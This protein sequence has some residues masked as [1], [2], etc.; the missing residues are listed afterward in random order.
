MP[1]HQSGCGESRHGD[2]VSKLHG[3]P[4]GRERD[5]G[6]AIDGLEDRRLSVTDLVRF[7]ER[8]DHREQH[9]RNP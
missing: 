9:Q 1:E 4:K 8:R 2:N 3:N 6:E 5:T 7:D